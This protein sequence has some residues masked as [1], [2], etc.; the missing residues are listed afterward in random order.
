MKNNAKV[1][2]SKIIEAEQA[3]AGTVVKDTSAFSRSMCGGMSIA[4]VILTV[5]E[6]A[7]GCVFE[8]RLPKNTDVARLAIERMRWKKVARDGWDG[9]GLFV[10]VQKG[11]PQGI[12][13]T[14][15]PQRP[16]A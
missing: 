7:E 9:K 16:W 15:R 3:C 13:A 4:S 2:W 8:A 6:G 12:R 1:P 11:Y 14:S 10:V 5:R